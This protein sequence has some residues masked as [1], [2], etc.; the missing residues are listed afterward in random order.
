MRKRQI[1]AFLVC[2]TSRLSPRVYHSLYFFKIRCDFMIKWGAGQ[3]REAPSGAWPTTCSGDHYWG[4]MWPPAIHDGPVSATTSLNSSALNS[5]KH[6]SPLRF[7]SS[8][9]QGT[10]TWL[11]TEPQGNVPYSA[12]WCRWTWWP[13]QCEPWLQSWGFPRVP[14]IPV[15]SWDWR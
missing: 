2:T 15:W 1:R 12:F 5:E 13:G 6:G 11:H 10:W 14:Y 9:T 3:H 4:C 8:G 7:G